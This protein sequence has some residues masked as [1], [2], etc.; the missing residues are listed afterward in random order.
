MLVT[1]RDDAPVRLL[2]CRVRAGQ[3]PARHSVYDAWQAQAQRLA[4]LAA[5]EG[6]A[7]ATRAGRL[8]VRE[9]VVRSAQREPPPPAATA[10]LTRTRC[11][12][13]RLLRVPP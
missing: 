2:D 11:E 9:E 12:T 13:R 7:Q 6:G 10:L 1:T 8:V 4:L 3:L 5:T